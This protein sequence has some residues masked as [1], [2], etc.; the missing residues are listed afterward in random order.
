MKKWLGKKKKV[1]VDPG[2]LP[3]GGAPSSSRET[4]PVEFIG[5]NSSP[6]DPTPAP[7][8]E[9]AQA[10]SR[11]P[12][13]EV[14]SVKPTYLDLESFTLPAAALPMFSKT[15][16]EEVELDRCRR[17]SDCFIHTFMDWTTKII[18][19]IPLYPIANEM[20]LLRTSLFHS[21]GKHIQVSSLDDDDG[22]FRRLGLARRIVY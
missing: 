17:C 9:P 20:L 8:R 12:P 14:L 6:S 10:G 18:I 2:T 19:G 11:G 16:D 21:N 13:I 7:L 3:S 1:S 22:K 4:A 5:P 15:R